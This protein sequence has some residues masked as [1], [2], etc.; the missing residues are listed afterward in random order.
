M[1]DTG[2]QRWILGAVFDAGHCDDC[3]VERTLEEDSIDAA[4]G[5]QA[6]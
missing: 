3:E 4:I 6:S 1:W 2:T 5:T